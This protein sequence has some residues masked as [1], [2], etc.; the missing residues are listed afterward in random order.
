MLSYVEIEIYYLVFLNLIQIENEN[1][2]YL[3]TEYCESDLR[4][5]ILR[6]FSLGVITQALI[7]MVSRFDSNAYNLSVNKQLNVVFSYTLSL[8]AIWLIH[9]KVIIKKFNYNQ[10]VFAKIILLMV[11]L[12]IYLFI[13]FDYGVYV[14]LLIIMFYFIIIRMYSSVYYYPYNYAQT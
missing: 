14:P 12:G 7:F 1:H 2:F 5:Y 8:I 4:K 9:E 11:I 10:N 3:I 6:L 13:P